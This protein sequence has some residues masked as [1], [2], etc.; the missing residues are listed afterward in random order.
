MELITVQ[1]ILEA[2]ENLKDVVT[3]TPCVLN[4]NLSNQFACELYLKREDLQ[5]VRSFKIRGAY[6]KMSLLSEEERARGIICASAGNHAQGVAMA[7]QKLKIKGTIVMPYPTP[8]QKV[9][10]V[11]HFGG[12]WVDIILEGDTFD[13]AYLV[14]MERKRSLEQTFIHP[15]DDPQVI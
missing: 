9:N 6:H 12:E 5:V 4:E 8:S 10:K 15:F 1:A 2:R 13:D 3:Q 14:A 11:R 7:C